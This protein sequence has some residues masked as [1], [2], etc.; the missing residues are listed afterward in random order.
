MI[1]DTTLLSRIQFGF[2]ISFHILFPSFSIGL[3][4]FLSIMEGIWLKTKNPLYLAICKFWTKVFALTF[5][6]GVVSGIVMEFQLGTNWA[7]FTHLV[8]GVLG[9]LFTYE[10]MTAFFIEAGFLGVMLFGWE[11][12][13]YRLHYFATLLVMIGTTLSA[14]WILSANTWMQHPVGYIQTG[15][16]LNV[17]SWP[18]IIFNPMLYVRFIHML[19]ASYIS[20]GLVISSVCAFYLLQKK[21]LDFSKV[22]FSFTWKALLVLIPLQI[23]VG[24]LVG[25]EVHHHQPLKTAAMEGLWETQRGAPFLAFAVPDQKNQTNYWSIP[26]PHAAA[27]INTHHWN[28]ELTGLKSAAPADQPMVALIFYT[29]RIM[30]YIGILMFL[31]ALM[32]QYLKIRKR[33]FDTPWFLNACVFFA[34][35]GFIALWCGWLTAEFGRQPWAIY[36]LLKTADAISPVSLQNV[37]ISFALIFIVYGIIFGYFY[38]YF[39]HKTIEKGPFVQHEHEP[40]HEP[41]SY[42]EP[43]TKQENQ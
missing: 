9:P 3:V 5:G 16:T 23:F 10:V 6:M 18:Q 22:C 13:G 28:G 39:L 41:F 19:F 37:I 27:L 2:T 34:P 29:F 31:L 7:G 26:I 42:M 35:A 30:V 38:F 21:H 25:L 8:G 11:K 40:I 17:V 36:N 14:Y 32:A 1:I 15:N 12:V 4:L 43:S 24:D 33:L 20:A